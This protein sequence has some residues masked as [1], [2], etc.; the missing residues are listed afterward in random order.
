MSSAR[1]SERVIAV[2]SRGGA[3]L[4]ADDDGYTLGTM[5]APNRMELCHL[6]L[7]PTGASRTGARRPSWFRDRDD[8]KP[9]THFLYVVHD[10][11]P[12]RTVL[13]KAGVLPFT[14]VSRLLSCDRASP[15]L[16]FSGAWLLRWQGRWTVREVVLQ[17]EDDHSPRQASR[18]SERTIPAEAIFRRA[19]TH[20]TYSHHSHDHA[21]MKA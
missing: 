1:G 15:A 10:A 7:S 19:R 9:T 5:L 16:R 12:D 18:N 11:L 3:I 2:F 17:L 14:A 13:R 6:H 8:K 21:S 4:L 20:Q